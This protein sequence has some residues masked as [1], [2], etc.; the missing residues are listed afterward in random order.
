V[1]S[2][3]VASV[4]FS[5]GSEA[6]SAVLQS[7]ETKSQA[8]QCFVSLTFSGWNPAPGYRQ[9]QGDF[10]YLEA[11]LIEGQTLF[12]TACRDGFFVNSSTFESFDP[13]PAERSF[14][15][16]SLVR[17]LELA[18]KRFKENF[19]RVRTALT[20]KSP[21]ELYNAP[22]RPRNWIGLQ[23]SHIYSANRAEDA[24]F[25]FTFHSNDSPG[26]LRDWNEELQM[27]RQ[28]PVT[29]VQEVIA[30]TR[31][32]CRFNRDFVE[33]ACRGVKAAV[34]RA[35]LPLNPIESDSQ[36]LFVFE[37]IFFSQV[38]DS[39]GLYK[40]L[41]GDEGAKSSFNIEMRS[42]SQFAEADTPGIALVA[43]C[44]IDYAGHRFTA[45]SLIPGILSSESASRVVYGCLDGKEANEESRKLVFDEEIHNML[46][47]FGKLCGFTESQ[48]EDPSD[49]TVKKIWGSGEIKVVVGTDGRKYIIEYSRSAPVDP[50]YQGPCKDL[51]PFRP[52]LISAYNAYLF[53]S[54]REKLI[55]VRETSH[56]RNTKKRAVESRVLFFLARVNE[57]ARDLSRTPRNT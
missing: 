35:I 7:V 11:K 8:S 12:I 43:V 46:A 34:S 45:Q 1:L 51:K 39:R 28:M 21:Y 16:H 30:R 54:A 56:E 14:K 53:R 31:N 17:L 18:S 27:I 19:K 22:E 25:S 20:S 38:V 36:H 57:C 44:I 52:E 33:A 40:E 24:L 42:A 6:L 26:Q 55:A 49:G 15:S 32:L 5:I 10:F 37:N 48:I 23:K 2:Q 41:G 9:L 50:A 13:R 29:N 4:P 47:P 3:D